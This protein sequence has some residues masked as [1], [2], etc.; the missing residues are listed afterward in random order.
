MMNDEGERDLSLMKW[1]FRLTYGK[2]RFNTRSEGVADADFWKDKFKKHR[3]IIPASSYFEWQGEKPPKPKY[4][5][6]VPGREYFGIAGLWSPWKD[7]KTDIW[8]NTF[9]TFT[10]EPNALI[11]KIHVRQPIILEPRDFSEWLAPPVRPPVH[12]LRVSLKRR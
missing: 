12:L 1:G 5:I 11:E 3:C 4:E 8:S 10:S 7:P 2:L 9:S 6:V